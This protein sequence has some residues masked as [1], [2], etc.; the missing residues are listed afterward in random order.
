MSA[1][2]D[3]GGARQALGAA[4][5]W[6]QSPPGAVRESSGRDE[7]ARLRWW[8]AQVGL[9]AAENDLQD[10]GRRVDAVLAAAA[11]GQLTSAMRR[12]YGAEAALALGDALS[13]GGDTAAAERRWTA[14]L[15]L[16][17]RATTDHHSRTVHAQALWRWAALKKP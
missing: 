12:R 15:S 5:Q 14:A 7:G 9:G 17:E 3:R 10:M 11:S 16:A 8:V 4:M 6:W 13:G 2:G 1:R